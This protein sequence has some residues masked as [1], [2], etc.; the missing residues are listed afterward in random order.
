[1]RINAHEVSTVRCTATGGPASA[2]GAR[3]A[4]IDRAVMG[5]NG[6]CQ[7]TGKVKLT[8][9][10]GGFTNECPSIFAMQFTA[11]MG[12]NGAVPLSF[13]EQLTGRCGSACVVL[14]MLIKASP[15][16]FR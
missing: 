12:R 5:T 8:R 11:L 7:L 16:S 2:T 6:A 3:T 4:S 15:S 14:D 13:S 10:V 9:R 1:M